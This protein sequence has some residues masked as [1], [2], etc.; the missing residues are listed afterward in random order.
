VAPPAA[1]SVG[2]ARCRRAVVPMRGPLVAPFR[3]PPRRRILVQL[4]ALLLHELH[5]EHAAALPA[6]LHLSRPCRPQT[7]QLGRNRHEV[8]AAAAAAAACGLR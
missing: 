6:K 5:F 4:A 7:P 3:G 1:A 8:A 2:V